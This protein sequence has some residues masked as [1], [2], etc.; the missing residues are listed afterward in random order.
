MFRI[1]LS[2]LLVWWFPILPSSGGVFP[3]PPLFYGVFWTFGKVKLTARSL[4]E[5]KVPLAKRRRT[6]VVDV[7]LRRGCFMWLFGLWCCLFVGM[8]ACLFVFDCRFVF[9][10]VALWPGLALSPLTPSGE[11]QPDYICP[12][13]L[14]ENLETK[15]KTVT[16]CSTPLFHTV[17]IILLKTYRIHFLCS[18][19]SSKT[20]TVWLLGKPL[21]LWKNQK[22]CCVSVHS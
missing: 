10:C 22:L 18:C 1:F 3:S 15:A 7:M 14:K 12:L 5:L 6:V 17:N 13:W 4:R 19:F 16:N 8:C 11:L 21:L 9:D 20:N 2:S